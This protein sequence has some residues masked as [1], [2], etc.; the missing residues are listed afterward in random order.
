VD[1][2][3]V[4]LLNG[5]SFGAVLFLLASGLSLIFGVMGVLNLAHG[6]LYMIGA[7]VGWSVAVQYGSSFWL[8]VLMGGLTAGFTGLVIERG[9]LRHLYKRLNE[10]ALLT[11]GFAHILTNLSLWIWG[12]LARPA[13]TAP[14]FSGSFSIGR[15]SY[16]KAR[17]FIIGVGLV[18]A[19]GL[20]WL[21]NKTRVGAIIRAGMD[22]KEMTMG[23][24]VDLERVSLAVFFLGSFIA[25]CAGVIG[26]QLLGANL[27]LG[28]NILLLSLVVIV[29][30]GM[31]S[32]EGAF[33]GSMVIGVIDAFGKALFPDL[34]MFTIYLVMILVLLARP[35]GLL[36][37]TA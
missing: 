20:W 27:Q 25:G 16:P 14:A 30:G 4:N 34:A 5:V 28:I 21:Q 18:L 11:F 2:F 26:A 15:V 8:G 37:R 13:F 17:V 24:G 1:F 22:D 9:F 12:P 6:T 31:G 29:L 36:G 19:I 3:V 35:T 7:Y 10:Q 32:V 23:L 33:L